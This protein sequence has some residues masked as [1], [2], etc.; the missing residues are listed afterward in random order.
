MGLKQ[1]ADRLVMALN[2]SGQTVRLEEKTFYSRKYERLITK[3]I[4]TRKN[5]DTGKW[6]R[7]LET[8]KLPEVVR[9]LA[10]MFREN[11]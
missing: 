5:A 6:E 4:V 10:E 8:Y 2:R 11:G 3:R 1:T 7:V 9:V